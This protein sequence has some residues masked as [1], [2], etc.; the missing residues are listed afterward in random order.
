M[1]AQTP[2]PFNGQKE[3]TFH[4][5]F[6]KLMLSLKTAQNPTAESRW[7]PE[8]FVPIK[9]E[10]GARVSDEFM[11]AADEGKIN[12]LK[13][14]NDGFARK[15]ARGLDLMAMH[16]INPRTGLASTVIGAN[17]FDAPFP[18]K[19]PTIQQIRMK[20]SSL[21]LLWFRDPEEM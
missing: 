16:G 4:D 2:I 15:V 5:G 3:F 1:T 11:Y 8:P 18:R 6:P 7:P 17:H 10:Y 19:F 21:L 20:T 12:I 9:V 13:A 14:F